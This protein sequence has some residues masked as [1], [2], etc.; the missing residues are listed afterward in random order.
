MKD[1]QVYRNQNILKYL[2]KWSIILKLFNFFNLVEC[3]AHFPSKILV[4]DSTMHK[5]VS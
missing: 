3:K 2:N 4:E 5:I 1:I